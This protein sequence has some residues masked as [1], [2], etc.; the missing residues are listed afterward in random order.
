M[1]ET[2]AERQRTARAKRRVEFEA[3]ADGMAWLHAFLP[4]DDAA[5]I[6]DRL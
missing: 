1:T 5:L 6:F 3:A 2:I 4:A